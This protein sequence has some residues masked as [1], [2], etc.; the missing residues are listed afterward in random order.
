MECQRRHGRMTMIGMSMQTLEDDTERMPWSR[1]SYLPI[2]TDLWGVAAGSA[3]GGVP[4]KALWRLPPRHPPK[5][6]CPPQD[7]F[8]VSASRGMLSVSTSKAPPPPPPPKA[9]FRC[10]PPRVARSM[11]YGEVQNPRVFPE[12]IQQICN[13]PAHGKMILRPTLLIILHTRKQ[14]RL[15]ILVHSIRME[16]GKTR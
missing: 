3:L 12:R 10:P 1:T 2:S 6:G 15:Y 9:R 8:S 11:V 7:T 4:P 5:A 16:I 14:D 13:K